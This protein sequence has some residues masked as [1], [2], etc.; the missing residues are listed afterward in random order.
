MILVLDSSALITLA[1]IGRLDVLRQVAGSVHIPEA[2][3]AEVIQGG[4]T[5]WGSEEVAQA[6]WDRSAPGSGSGGRPSLS[7]AGGQGRS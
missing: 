3:F 6:P 4:P 5:R 1:R 7:G 2:V